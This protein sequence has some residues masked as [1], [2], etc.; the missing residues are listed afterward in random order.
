MQTPDISRLSDHERK[1]YLEGQRIVARK[2]AAFRA[3]NPTAEM[4]HERSMREGK[5]QV[6]H[7]LASASRAR[8]L[9]TS[10]APS[11]STPSATITAHQLQSLAKAAHTAAKAAAKSC[12][13][14]QA[15]QQTAREA[16]RGLSHHR[17]FCR[18]GLVGATL[19]GRILA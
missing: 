3:A 17:I 12:A 6:A 15:P 7:R 14:A 19:N 1:T 18:G 11:A 16:Y 13:A 2:L 5:A 4:I 10:T 9:A 8:T